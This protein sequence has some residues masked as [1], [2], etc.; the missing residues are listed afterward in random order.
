MQSRSPRWMTLPCPSASTCTSTWRGI[1]DQLLDVDVGIGEVR[2]PLPLRRLERLRGA[3]R[4]LDDLHPL[5]A[6]ARGGLDQ[7]RVA[8]RPAELQQLLDRADRVGR[9][10]DDRHARVLHHP[11]RPRLL[12][13]QLD[14]RRRR[15]DPDEP[16]VLDGARERRVLGEEPVAGMH[17]ARAGALGGLHEALDLQIALGRRRRADQIRLVGERDVQRAAVGLGVDRHRPDPELPQR[18]EDA[19]GDLPAVGDENLVEHSPYSPRW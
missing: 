5:A 9:A 13:H 8:D 4:P 1:D 12:A 19:D 10:G 18:P 15:A 7:Q 6:A 2:L 14:R 3:V 17:G 16:R 11:P